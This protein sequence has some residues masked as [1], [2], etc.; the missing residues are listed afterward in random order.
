MK[1]EGITYY[2]RNIEIKVIENVE[3]LSE[4][5]RKRSM[6]LE[7]LLL[8]DFF[9]KTYILKFQQISK[10][11]KYKGFKRVRS[12]SFHRKKK[13]FISLSR[14]QTVTKLRIKNV[15]NPI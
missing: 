3:F 6:K 4:Y 2:Y 14:L 5:E 8:R 1:Q 13:H 12:K 11:S 9:K 10:Y 7:T 15:I